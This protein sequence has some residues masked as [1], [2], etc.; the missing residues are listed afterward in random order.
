MSA[1]AWDGE[2]D[3]EAEDEAESPPSKREQE[4]AHHQPNPI[5]EAENWLRYT[6]R[7]IFRMIM[8]LVRWTDFWEYTHKGKTK[9]L[10]YYRFEFLLQL[11]MA[12]L[13]TEYDD[14]R[15]ASVLLSTQEWVS[16]LRSHPQYEPIRD[17]VR[18]AMQRI[19]ETHGIDGWA[20]LVEDQASMTVAATALFSKSGREKQV[21]ADALLDRRSAKKGRGG[22][23]PEV[24]LHLPPGFE[25]TRDRALQIHAEL[26]AR[27][28][29]P[30]SIEDDFIDASFIR[31]PDEEGA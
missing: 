4:Q 9:Q 23:G 10:A 29:L 26:A 22:E 24:H 8:Q 13:L 25:A 17:G 18:K 16:K 5:Q 19:K 28:A 30:S 7:M 2:W 31:V 3:D 12:D 20:E 1:E 14:K 21:A 6:H 27:K 11:A 15:K